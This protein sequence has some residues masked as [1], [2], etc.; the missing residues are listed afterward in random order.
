MNSGIRFSVAL[1]VVIMV[2]LGFYYASLDDGTVEGDGDAAAPEIVVDPVIDPVT[3]D[4][5]DGRST[6]VEPQATETTDPVRPQ[7]REVIEPAVD[8]VVEPASGA[9]PATDTGSETDVAAGFEEFDEFGGE[10]DAGI[11]DPAGGTATEPVTD[12]DDGS[13]MPEPD[14]TE[15]SM[16]P[17]TDDDG[18]STPDGVTPATGGIDPVRPTTPR[19][20][21]VVRAPGATGVGLHRLASIERDQAIVNAAMRA[22]A[23]AGSPGIIEGPSGSAWIPLPDGIADDL[24]SGAITDRIPG[25]DTRHV[26]ILTGEGDVVDLAGRIQSTEVSGSEA[27]GGW[28]LGFRLA[29]KDGESVRVA[30]RGLIGQS[31]AW[32]GGGRVLTIGRQ[33]IPISGQANV[34]I[35]FASEAAATAVA[36]LLDG[37]SAATDA[38]SNAPSRDP[39]PRNIVVGPGSLPPDQYTDYVV[40]PGDTFESI[41]AAWFG[42]PNKHSLIAIAN[43]YTE[44]SRLAIGQVLRLPPRDAELPVEIPTAGGGGGPTI[45]TVRSGDTLGR[46]AQRAYGKAS[47]WTRIYEANKALLG[48][49]PGSIKVG[50]ELEIPE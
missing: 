10:T 22:L 1:I 42:D 23:D 34:P 12:T 11:T 16:D 45:Y 8:P 33:V 26:L 24:L 21:D 44:S 3:N 49:D 29:A 20:T 38:S 28:S 4:E 43:P 39:Q 25:D 32:I 48:D 40:K 5:R 14:A 50:M 15:T 2:L 35:R 13:V 37:A 9:D 46:I 36:R 7:P 17:A 30:S 27:A 19:S 47:L 6:P 31:V 41:A 18:I